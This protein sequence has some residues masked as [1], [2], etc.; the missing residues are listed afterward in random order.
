MDHVNEANGSKEV[1]ELDWFIL[2]INITLNLWR[3][4][5]W[6]RGAGETDNR[7]SNGNSNFNNNTKLNGNMKMVRSNGIP[8]V[9]QILKYAFYKLISTLKID[10]GVSNPK[11]GPSK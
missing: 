7:N 4:I 11:A 6:S 3:K 10:I 9:V 8:A 2:L 1:D 5:T